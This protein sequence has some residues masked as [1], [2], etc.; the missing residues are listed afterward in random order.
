VAIDTMDGEEHVKTGVKTMAVIGGALALLGLGGGSEAG[1]AYTPATRDSL[2]GIT[3]IAVLVDT[4]AAE[5]E[6]DG[7]TRSQLQTD[8]ELRLREAGLPVVAKATDVLLYVN[9]HALR[10]RERTLYVYSIQV[11]VLQPVTVTRTG[12]PARAGTWFT[13]TLGMAGTAKLAIVRDDL[14]A[15]VDR[16]L[17]AWLA[18]N[19]R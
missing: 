3:A 8:V 17:T 9:V 16:F 14:R 5:A 4:F 15:A 6:A 13:A 18:M 19:P 1:M 7:L 11:N 12:T 2:K 10:S